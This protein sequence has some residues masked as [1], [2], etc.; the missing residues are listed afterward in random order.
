M[1]QTNQNHMLTYEACD[2]CS[3]T[4]CSSNRISL[5]VGP[6][7]RISDVLLCFPQ[8]AA[9]FSEAYVELYVE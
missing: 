4:H 8:R 7:D 6:Q 9:E 1:R 5:G 2:K 3:G